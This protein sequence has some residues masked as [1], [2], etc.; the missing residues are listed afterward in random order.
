MGAAGQTEMDL[1]KP[2]PALNLDVD[3]Y[4]L[5][6]EWSG[7]SILGTR[8]WYAAMDN[9]GSMAWHVG[10]RVLIHLKGVVLEAL[11]L[12]RCSDYFITMWHGPFTAPQLNDFAGAHT[13]A[14]CAAVGVCQTNQG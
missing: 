2:A 3:D 13:C 7:E 4:S 8:G 1:E 12:Y 10:D 6:T 9:D 5:P 14:D 11:N